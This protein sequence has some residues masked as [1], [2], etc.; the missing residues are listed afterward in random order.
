[1][2]QP[3]C[4]GVD[5][6]NCFLWNDKWLSNAI[7]PSLW[8]MWLKLI[9][10]LPLSGIIL[11]ILFAIWLRQSRTYPRNTMNIQVGSWLWTIW[12]IFEM[13]KPWQ[14]YEY[15]YFCYSIVSECTTISCLLLHV[16]DVLIHMKQ[17]IG[18]AQWMCSSQQSYQI[19]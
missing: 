16:W 13:L 2:H 5:D 4:K 8:C 19:F 7:Y 3:Q 18:S 14:Q 11:T 1:M 15:S 12:S 10:T 6:Q 9:Y 17:P